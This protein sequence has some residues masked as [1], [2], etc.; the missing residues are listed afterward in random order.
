MPVVMV[1]SVVLMRATKNATDGKDRTFAVVDYTGVLGEPLV[2]VA[3]VLNAGSGDLAD[4]QA[5]RTTPRFIPVVVKPDG[6]NPDELR[7]ELSDRVRREELFAFVEL[8]AEL[9]DPAAKVQIR[10]YS[11][12]PSYNALPIWLRA[13]LNGIVL[14][15]RFR[16]AAIDRALVARLTRQ[17]PVENLGLF[18][19]GSAGTVKQAEEVDQVRAQGVP[20][21]MLI[22]MYI[23]VMSSAPQLLNS[24]IEEKMSRISEVLMGAITP[25]QLMMGKLI[26]SVAVSVLLAAIYIA[27]GLVVGQYWAATRAP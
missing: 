5:T 22:L 3:Q 25:F 8:P 13:T 15:E 20:L 10:Y 23:T 6:R 1:L 27:G 16:R 11:N 24:V 26:G 17:A 2:A 18:E 7:L 14:N 4:P 21:A 12:H 9:L 19:R